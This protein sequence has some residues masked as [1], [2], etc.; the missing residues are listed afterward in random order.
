MH[1]GFSEIRN[2]YHTNF[3]A[4]YTG[5]IPLS[6]KAGKEVERMVGVWGD[7]RKVTREV[8][9]GK[10]DGGFLFGEFGVVDAFF[11]LCFG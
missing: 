6:E 10:G 4:R 11:G 8:L 5:K 7:A 2:T 1:S 3:L 9:G